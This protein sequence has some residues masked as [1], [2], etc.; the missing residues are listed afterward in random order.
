MPNTW[1]LHEGDARVGYACVEHYG[2]RGYVRHVVIGPSQRGR[3]LG[4]RMMDAIAAHLRGLGAREWELNVRREN[5]PALHLYG[6][7]GMREEYVTFVLRLEWALVERLPAPM[8]PPRFETL[9]PECDTDCE[10]A[11][12]MPAGQLAGYRR[13]SANALARLLEDDGRIVGI[14]RF[15][16]TFPG[17]FPFRVKETEY[18][19]SLLEGLRPLAPKRPTWL[20]LVIEDDLPAVALLLEIGAQQVFEIVH[21]RG[22]ILS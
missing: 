1:F 3:G 8:L 2:E 21:M 16:P 7:V 14:A 20:Q 19:R 17:A 6:A 4:R 13:H 18:V 5:A 10:R 9:R 12:G 11:F 22:R 15:D